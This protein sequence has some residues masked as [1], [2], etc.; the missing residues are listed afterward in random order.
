MLKRAT[1]HATTTAETATASGVVS[2]ATSTSAETNT[3]LVAKD[4]FGVEKRLSAGSRRPDLSFCEMP[5]WFYWA[6]ATFFIVC[7]IFSAIV[8]VE[9]GLTT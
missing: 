4:G 5:T 7:S 6:A 1:T 2:A 3:P 8:S 9:N